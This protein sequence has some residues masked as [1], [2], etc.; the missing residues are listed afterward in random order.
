MIYVCIPSYNEAPTLGLLLWKTRQVFTAFTREYQLIVCDD[1]S[2]D[3]TAELLE[4][5][6]RVLPLSVIR[7]PERRGYAAAVE[8][9]LRLAVER[10]DRPKRDCAIVMHADFTHSPHYI[11]DLVR[12]IDSGADVVVA[13]GRVQGEPSSGYRWIRWLA[14]RLLRGRLSI[15]GVTDVVSGFSAFRLIALRN[16]F[17]SHPEPLLTSDGW[18][19]NAELLGYAARHARR[20]ETVDAVERHDL[21]RRPSRV[22]PWDMTVSMWRASRALSLRPPHSE[23]LDTLA[24]REPT[25]VGQ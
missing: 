23:P 19:V 4:P 12:R 2:T 9:L 1:G 18:A 7:H 24:H 10:T 5:Y 14:P 6:A 13:E 20:I 15:P 22:A 21:R 25:T 17:R 8:A 3:A 11:P 16:A